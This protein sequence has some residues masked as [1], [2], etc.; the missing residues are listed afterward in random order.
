[1]A[2]Q[3]T[4]NIGR[5]QLSGEGK[6]RIYPFQTPLPLLSWKKEEGSTK[7]IK[8]LLKFLKQIDETN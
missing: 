1:M 3:N 6:N 5:I 7:E 8:L 2:E 4:P